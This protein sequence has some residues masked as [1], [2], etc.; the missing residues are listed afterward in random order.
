MSSHLFEFLN[1]VIKAYW[2]NAKVFA[3]KLIWMSDQT[4]KSWMDFNTHVRRSTVTTVKKSDKKVFKATEKS[5]GYVFPNMP[6]IKKMW[7]KRNDFQ[8]SS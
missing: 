5:K 7:E 8:S 2:E 4:I 3:A 1:G 6:E